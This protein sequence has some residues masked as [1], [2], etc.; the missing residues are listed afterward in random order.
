MTLEA[1]CTRLFQAVAFSHQPPQVTTTSCLWASG[2]SYQSLVTLGHGSQLP[3]GAQVAGTSCSW[4]RATATCR[5]MA[6]CYQSLDGPGPRLLANG[7]PVP[8]LVVAYETQ[9]ALPSRL[10]HSKHIKNIL[11]YM[12]TMR[13]F[14]PMIPIFFGLYLYTLV[15]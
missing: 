9:V 10:G 14:A 1:T 5:P 4:P 12:I 15:P 3:M 8:W 11:F 13:V 7:H 6:S 2:R